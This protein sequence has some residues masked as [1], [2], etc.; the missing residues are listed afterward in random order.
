MAFLQNPWVRWLLLPL[1]GALMNVGLNAANRLI[2]SPLFVDSILTA[3][4]SALAGWGPGLLTA[5]ETQL[6]MEVGLALIGAGGTALP[7]VFCGFATATV[8][9]LMARAGRFRTAFHLVVATVAVT[10]LNA[11]IGAFTALYVFGGITLHTSDFL[12]TGL[13]LGGQTLQEAAFWVRIPLNLV[14]KGL[15]VGLAFVAWNALRPKASTGA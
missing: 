2:P 12:V 5:L 10:L 15:A 7:F 14:D 1:I 13:L 11:V 8:V 3:V 6:G 4:V 9:A